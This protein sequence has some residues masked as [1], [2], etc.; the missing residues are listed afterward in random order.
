MANVYRYSPETVTCIEVNYQNG[1][2]IWET[3]GTWLKVK[4][5]V[6]A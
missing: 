3:L 5:K 6:L 1:L 4:A 2:I